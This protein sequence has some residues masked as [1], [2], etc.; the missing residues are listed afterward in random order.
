M[1]SW[2]LDF[3]NA[4][5]L[6]AIYHIFGNFSRLSL[7]Y[8]HINKKILILFGVPSVILTVV[9]A[10]LAAHIDQTIL[11]MVLGIVLATF[12]SYALWKP[13]RSVKPTKLL[14]IIGGGLS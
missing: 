12:A 8:K 13:E 1:V 14:G 6:V 5:L 4:L 2:I 10:S 9:G 3:H 11:K 7:F